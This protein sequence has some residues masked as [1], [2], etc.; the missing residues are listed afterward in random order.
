MASNISTELSNIGNFCLERTQEQQNEIAACLIS[1]YID[2]P[3]LNAFF[4]FTD[5]FDQSNCIVCSHSNM[6][7]YS[8]FAFFDEEDLLDLSGM[9]YNHYYCVF[10]VYDYNFKERTAQI[11]R[12]MDYFCVHKKMLYSVNTK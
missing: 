7:V 6:D 12:F 10:P 4:C 2:S 8:C 3:D 11:L 1:K 9:I 5:E